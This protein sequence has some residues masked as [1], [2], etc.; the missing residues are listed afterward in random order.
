MKPLEGA[1][2][3]AAKTM[4]PRLRRRT[5]LAVAAMLI[6]LASAAGALADAG[7]VEL[8]VVDRDTGQ[9]LRVWRHDGRL[10]VAGQPGARYSL[11]LANHTDG[12]VLVVLSVDGVNVISGETAGYDQRGYV[13]WAGQSYDVSGWRKSNSE[14]AAFTFAPLPQSYAA[15]TGRPG[16]VGVIGMA[17]FAE[18][19]AVPAPAAAA[20]PAS[21]DQQPAW[22]RESSRSALAAARP[23]APL[24]P[25][26]PG[27]APPPPLELPPAPKA[28][29][30]SNMV[31]TARRAADA[32][33]PAHDQRAAEALSSQQDEKLGTAHGAR[34]WSVV[35][36]TTF[37]RSTPYPIY[38]RRI[39]YDTYDNLVANGVAPPIENAEHRPRPFPLEPGAAGY[40]PDPPPEP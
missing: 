31:V 13:L 26:P 17:V 23:R 22:R 12:R 4:S 35:N 15:L 25:P 8:S 9:V 20:A 32:P 7:P 38:I 28:P 1:C 5:A 2:M 11:R 10:F 21:P 19:Y 33:A 29:P 3:T 14:V 37:V 34:E 39:E 18:Q 40:V 36:L 6:G 27:M 16:D 30:P 24:L